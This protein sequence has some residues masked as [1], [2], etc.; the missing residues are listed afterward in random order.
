M[1]ILKQVN[2]NFCSALLVLVVLLLSISSVSATESVGYYAKTYPNTNKYLKDAFNE[3]VHDVHIF[4]DSCVDITE[5]FIL[6]NQN[7]AWESVMENYASGGYLLKVSKTDEPEISVPTPYVSQSVSKETDWIYKIL[8]YNGRKTSNEFGGKV[9]AVCTFNDAIGQYTNIGNP[10]IYKGSLTSGNVSDIKLTYS[11]T[12][13]T[14][15][16]KVTYS[17]FSFL[18][19]DEQY[20]NNSGMGLYYDKF[21]IPDTLTF[22]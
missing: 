8:E 12:V 14:N 18:V 11:K 7:K 2:R 1:K 15:K 13:A 5:Q 9:K 4:D 16:R 21:S 17:K 19:Y 22:N 3:N 10:Y 20:G 6:D